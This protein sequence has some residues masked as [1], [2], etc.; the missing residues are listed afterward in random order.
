[1]AF[2]IGF[3]TDLHRL[4]EG[5]PLV[6]GGVTIPYHKGP[7][8]HSDGDVLIHAICDALLGALALRDIGYHFPNH[9]PRYKG[10]SSMLFLRETLAMVHQQ[11]WKPGNLD[12]TIHLEEPKLSPYIPAIQ[13]SLA[14]AIG[15]SPDTV[16]IKAKTGEKVGVIGEGNAI[17]ALVICLL[18]P[19]E[20]S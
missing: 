18:V 19:A 3:G 9:D 17:E 7:A 13:T 15:I 20:I 14:N 8:G 2:R 4:E 1:M 10:A 6:L 5:I 16:S 12:A 11:G